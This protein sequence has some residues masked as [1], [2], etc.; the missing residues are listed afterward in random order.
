MHTPAWQKKKAIPSFGERRRSEL[1]WETNDNI[2]SSEGHVTPYVSHRRH[3]C[4]ATVAFPNKQCDRDPGALRLR[5]EVFLRLWDPSRPLGL[6]E[7]EGCKVKTSRGRRREG[8]GGWGW[9]VGRK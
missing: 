8:V 3:F 1:V 7:D 2:S 6:G 9:G 4:R 5:S